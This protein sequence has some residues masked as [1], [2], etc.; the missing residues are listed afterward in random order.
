[1]KKKRTTLKDLEETV[2]SLKWRVLGI[3]R[4]CEKAHKNLRYLKR[5]VEA[6]EKGQDNFL[7]RFIKNLYATIK[8]VFLVLG[9]ILTC[10]IPIIGPVILVT[11]FDKEDSINCEGD[12]TFFSV[13]FNIFFIIIYTSVF[14]KGVING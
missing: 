14:I 2:D 12:I 11:L 6:F 4:N 10:S 1:M 9:F 8:Y 5:R 3:G 7:K 13:V